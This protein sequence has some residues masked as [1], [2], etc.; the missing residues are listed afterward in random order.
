[1]DVARLRKIVINSLYSHR[2]VFLR[3]L[4]SNANDA[5][6][7]L[8]IT[9]LTDKLS[10]E[11]P[12]NITIKAIPNADGPG[13]RLVLTDYG[14]GMSAEDLAANLGTV[15]KSGTSDFLTKAEGGDAS[16]LI[17]Q[18]GVGF[19]SSFLVADQVY[20]AS[21]PRPSKENPEPTQN[22]FSSNAE[23]SSFDVYPDPRG[24]TLGRGT[25][26]TLVLKDDALEYLGGDRLRELVQIH[27]A[28]STNFPIYL[29]EI[30]TEE[31]ADEEVE[32]TTPVDDDEEA[33]IVEELSESEEVMTDASVPIPMKNVTSEVW[34]HLNDVQPL[35]QRPAKDVSTEEYNEFYRQTYKDS[36]NPIGMHHFKGDAGAISFKA[37]LFIP[38]VLDRDYWTTASPI[39]HSIR[40]LVKRVFITSDFGDN[41]LPKWISWLK[42]IVDADDLPLNVSR[43]TLQ[44]TRFL[45]QV[46]QVLINKAI[47][48]LA[49]ISEEDPEKYKKVIEVYGAALK[50]G[51]VESAKE[52]QKIVGLTRW[53]TNLRNFTSLDQIVGD[54]KKGQ[55][56]IFYLAQAGSTPELL[57]KSV[58]IEKLNARG[59][60]VLLCTEPMD[61]IL[62]QNLRQWKGMAFQDVSKKGLEFGDEDAE[63]E[64]AELEE[65]KTKFE[66]LMTYMKEFAK[67]SVRDVMITTRLVQSACAIVAD[68][69]GYSANMERLMQAQNQGKPNKDGQ[70]YM[71]EWARKQRA[72]EINPRSPLIEGLLR[73]IV[74]LTDI[75]E[76][77]EKDAEL[78]K[79]VQEIAGILI[80]SA[81]VRSGFDVTDSNEFFERIDR[82]LRRA[83]GVA[84]DAPTDTTVAP[85]P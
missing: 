44:S 58:F 46:K 17:G 83:V 19:Y 3:E 20:V 4:I 70:Q 43:E 38:P 15:A 18:F 12:L 33:A 57:A 75:E 36:N 22:V 42:A 25:E 28:F 59:Y 27:S 14:I 54:K 26:I 60:E 85:G 1:S 61:E 23:D 45:K 73:K 76:G 11:Q 82:V 65:L 77:E 39:A 34:A 13:G 52:R 31:P 37:M 71:H 2:D 84:E 49:R 30:R 21:I 78:E 48:L 81:L 80:D 63:A 55:N 16:N 7:K 41:G 51:A 69:F 72:L 10:E 74:R 6:E 64:K 66:P 40:L 9:S 62:I 35:W 5:L 32:E 67:E 56:H 29:H 47:A 68:Q 79:E 53:S 24:N 50:L 8:R